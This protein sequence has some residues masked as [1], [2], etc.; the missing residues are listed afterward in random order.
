VCVCVYTGWVKNRTVF[1]V[2]SFVTVSVK[3]VCMSKV[4]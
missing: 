3:K 4:S 2:D 1:R